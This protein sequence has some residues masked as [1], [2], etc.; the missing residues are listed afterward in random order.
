MVPYLVKVQDA[1]QRLQEVPDNADPVDR[2]SHLDNLDMALL[3]MKMSIEE[4]EDVH[5]GIQTRYLL[6]FKMIVG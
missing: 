2:K 4:F 1:F 6:D 5:V 3:D